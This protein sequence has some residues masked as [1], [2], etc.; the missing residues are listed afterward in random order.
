M[1]KTILKGLAVVAVLGIAFVHWFL[2]ALIEG[3]MNVDESHEPYQI[4]PEAARFHK[5]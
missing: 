1:G 5:T 4:R 2:P 3:S